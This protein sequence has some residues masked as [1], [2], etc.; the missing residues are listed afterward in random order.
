MRYIDALRNPLQVCLAIDELDADWPL[1]SGEQ[2]EDEDVRW[3]RDLILRE[4]AQDYMLRGLLIRE[5]NGDL[6][7]VVPKRMQAQIIR[8]A[9]DHFSVDK[10]EELVKNDYWIPNL[11]RRG[12]A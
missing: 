4:Q 11:R 1:G 12:R 7:L 2:R 3:L 10:T 6:Q 5:Y 9:R 8:Q